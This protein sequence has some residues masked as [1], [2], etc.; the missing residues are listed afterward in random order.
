MQYVQYVQYN[1]GMAIDQLDQHTIDKARELAEV[2]G[3]NVCAYTGNDTLTGALAGALGQAQY[4]LRELVAITERLADDSGK[5]NAAVTA[6]DEVARILA[7]F[8]WERDDR[9]YALERIE[10]IVLTGHQQ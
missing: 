5:N 2:T 7:D 10:M 6:F 8:D 4:L 1:E 9:Q 3:H